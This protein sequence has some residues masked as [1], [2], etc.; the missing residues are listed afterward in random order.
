MKK[1]GVG[2]LYAGIASQLRQ[3]R[4]ARPKDRRPADRRPRPPKAEAAPA[5]KP[6]LRVVG[7]SD[8]SQ[9]KVAAAEPGAK[10]RMKIGDVAMA[11][12]KRKGAPRINPFISA[13]HPPGVF[14]AGHRT[15]LAQDEAINTA[16]A[17]A[18]QQIL[19]GVWEAGLS[20]MGY[21][22]LSELAQR[23]E[24]RVIVET[25]ATE[26]TRKW[27][28]LQATTEDD[29]EDRTARLNE[30][31]D[32]LERLKLRDVMRT[33]SAHDGFF[34]RGHVYLDLGDTD[35][36]D[37]LLTPIGD[38]RNKISQTKVGKKRKLRRLQNVEPIWCYP[39]Q[40]NSNNPLKQ[41]WYNP[42]HWFCMGMEIH[43]SRLLPFVAREV[44]DLLKP[45][46]SFGGLAM[47][48]MAKPTVDNWLRT[49]QSVSDI[50]HAFS[51]MVL[52]TDMSESL[53]ESGDQLFTRLDFFNANRDNRGI[54]AINKD[55]EELENVAVPLSSLDLL[56]AQAQ[57]H[58]ASISRTPIVKLLGIQPAGLNASSEGEMNTW[59][60]WVAAYQEMFFREPVTR[61]VGFAM[62]NL[63][64]KI[65]KSITFK[66]EPLRQMTEKERA[67]LKKAE[68]DADGVYVDKG[69][70]D[71]VEV[72]AR[73]AGAEDSPYASINVEDVPEPP[74]EGENDKADRDQPPVE[75]TTESAS[76][77]ESE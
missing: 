30:L 38:G 10:K 76:E 31:N 74:I 61:I 9:P 55:S 17:W 41:T 42:S 19:A 52:K 57:E 32:E 48:Q 40:Y 45:A 60:D 16:N 66:F 1:N 36:R 50:T 20:F 49:R 6:K 51:C 64:G 39:A 34:G 69:V 26:S 68:A 27:I 11:R 18:A 43:R 54:M 12:A 65:D 2:D 8:Q 75:E 70:L 56:Q 71:P 21:P 29:G 67:E 23:A 44:P 3:P 33:A 22:Y 63:W 4:D 62:L 72:R 28:K 46:Y 14:P 73:L 15:P 53:S 13:N 58:M 35:D 47:T 59:D 7:G 24:Y 25:L 37:E 77:A 5:T